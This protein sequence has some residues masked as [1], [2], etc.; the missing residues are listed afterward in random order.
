MKTELL[1]KNFQEATQVPVRLMKA[2]AEVELPGTLH[3]I[4]RRSLENSDSAIECMRF[5]KK[6]TAAENDSHAI[7]WAG[8]PSGLYYGL[9]TVESSSQVLM[10]VEVGPVESRD[11]FEA[12]LPLLEYIVSKLHEESPNLAQTM[13]SKGPEFLHKALNHIEENFDQSTTLTDTA[14]IVGLSP[15]RFSRVFR[16]HTGKTFSAYIAER[17]IDKAC[18]ILKN[19]PHS[20]ISDIAMDC[21]FDSIPYFNRLFFK[22]IGL[23]PSG[24]RMKKQEI[25]LV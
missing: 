11:K 21:G 13:G 5:H 9:M 22:H 16:K 4:C 20:R 12:A 18:R 3:T 15:D 7:E 10:R 25:D 6:L 17:R 19:S 8:C 23:S 24:F 2:D 14:R 1:L